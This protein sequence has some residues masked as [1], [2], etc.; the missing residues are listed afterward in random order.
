[1]KQLLAGAAI[2]LVVGV[3][4]FLYRNTVER[5]GIT[6]A[7]PV[8]TLEAKVCP[9]GSSVGRIGRSCA[10]APCMPPNVEL[11]D[12]G[13]AF[14]VPG[15]Y[16]AIESKSALIAFAKPSLSASVSHTLSVHRYIVP[17]GKTA[18]EVM[19]ENTR[20][21]PADMRA[22]DFGRFEEVSVNGTVFQWVVIERFEAL[23]HSS[24]YL[25]RENDVLRFDIV[26]HDVTA[27]MEPTLVVGE[28]PEH[29]ALL[30]ALRTLQYT[31]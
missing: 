22:E 6:A 20:Y 5:P 26:E 25:V 15:G 19:L 27:W 11:Q 14:V 12:A 3:G 8:C 2:L 7:E 4:S 9:D 31:P 29:G 28:L 13:I 24:Y 10:F 17:E 1:M 18:E 16:G 23:V 21:Q 30:E